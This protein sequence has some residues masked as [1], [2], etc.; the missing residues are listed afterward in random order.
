MHNVS[1]H[2]DKVTTV[3]Q[4]TPQNPPVFGNY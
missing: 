4:L 3:A 1:D 2:I